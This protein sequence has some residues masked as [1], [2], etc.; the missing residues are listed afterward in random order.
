VHLGIILV[1][2]QYDALFT[3]YL[4]IALLYM[5]PA[6]RCSSWGGSNCINTSSGYVTLCRWLPGMPVLPDQHTR[7][8]PTQS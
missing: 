7:Q 2:N 1:K 8:S 6:A 5:Y 4:F 3:M